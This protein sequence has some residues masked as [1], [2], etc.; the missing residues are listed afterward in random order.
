[1]ALTPE[2]LARLGLAEDA[3]EQ[4]INEAVAASLAA[5][6]APATTE[7]PAGGGTSPQPIGPAYPQPS[8]VPPLG[9]ETVA[10]AETG[11]PAPEAMAA[12][13]AANGAVVIDSA[14][15]AAHQER[16]AATEDQLKA[17]AERERIATRDKIVND[18][19]AAGKFPPARVEAIKSLYDM[20]PEGTTAHLQTL[21]AGMIPTSERGG[22]PAPNDGSGDDTD[23]YPNEW[24]SAR[25]RTRLE[26]A[27][28]GVYQHAEV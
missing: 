7:T 12:A 18:A 24:L 28:Q 8:G 23:A 20:D 9:T 14:A 4:Q 10:P 2:N 25:E 3:T 21:Q 1:M 6:S 13:A 16:L 5:P 27:R 22:M 17:S 15:W 26:S 19:L 11:T